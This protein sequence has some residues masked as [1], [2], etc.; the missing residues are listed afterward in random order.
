M[1][2]KTHINKTAAKQKHKNINGK[3]TNQKN[4]TNLKTTKQQ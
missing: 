3:H 1:N 4:K 2:H